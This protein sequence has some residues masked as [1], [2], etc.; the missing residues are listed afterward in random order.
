M[1]RT[2]GRLLSVISV[3]LI[4]TGLTAPVASAHPEGLH[5]LLFTKTAAGAYRHDSIPAGIAMFEQLAADREW[6]LTK[7]E[8]S[9][10]FNDAELATFDVVVM[11]QTSGMVWDTDAQR[12]AVQNY[13][14]GGGGIVAIHNATDMNIEGE[15]PWWDQMLGMSMTQHSSIVPGTAKVAD[16]KH[17]SGQALP[18]RWDR[19]EEWYNFDHSGR[20]DVHVLVTADETTYD[21]GPAKMGHDHPIS[22]CRNIEG[23]RLWATGMGH[24]A[25]TYSEPLFAEHVAGGVESSGGKVT[26]DCGP[27]VWNS[28]EKVALDDATVGPG[29]LDVAK[30]GRVFYAEYGGKVKIFKPDTSQIVTGATLDVYTGG[31]DGLTG[32]ALD[33][34]FATNKWIYL[35]YSPS[36]GGEDIA[37]VSRFTVNGD[38]LDP[39]SEKVIMKVPSSRQAPEPGHTGGYITFGPNGDLHIG[40]GDDIEPFRSDGYAPIDERPGHADNDV[41]GTSANTNDLRGKILRIHPEAD[42]TYTIPSGNMFA[43]GTAKTKPEI[44]AMGFRNPFRFTVAPDGKIYMADYAADASE[45]DPARGPAATTEWNII[46]SPGFY[47]WPYCVGDNIPYVDYDFGTGQSGAKFDCDKPVNTSPN[48]TGLTELPAARKAD[49]WYGGGANGNKFPEMGQG[50][51]APAAFPLYQYDPDNPSKTKFPAYFDNTPFFGE[52]SRNKLFEFRLGEDEKLLKIN[53]FLSNMDFRSPMDMKFGPDGAMYLLEWGTGFG[54]DNPDSGLYRIDYMSGDRSPVAKAAVDKDSGATPLAVKFSSAGS[55]DPENS[56]VTYNWEFGDGGTSTEANPAH[57]FTAKGEF[58]VKL[59]VTDSGGKTGVTNLKVIAGNTRPTV[60][61]SVPEGGMF[62]WGDSVPYTVN[63]VDPED[64][65]VDCTKVSTLPALGHDTHP[66]EGQPIPGCSGV[67]KPESDASH[68]GLNTVFVATSSYT[69]KGATGVPSLEGK[70]RVLMQPKHKQAEFYTG[71]SGVGVV[72]Q[73][74]AESGA[75]IGHIGDNDWA[76]FKSYNFAGIEKVSIRLSSPNGGGSVELRAGSPTGA[77]IATVPVQSTGDWD[78]YVSMPPVN[79]TDPGGTTELFMVFKSPSPS[80]YDIDSMTFI[81]PG[82]TDVSKQIVGI[83]GKC[84]DVKDGTKVQMWTCDEGA[85]QAWTQSGQTLRAVGKCMDVSGVFSTVQLRT[86]N[87]TPA[88]N[89]SVEPDGTIRNGGKCLDVPL[90]WPANGIRL[91][92]FWCHGGRNQKWTLS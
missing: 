14:H 29:A 5:V 91:V 51:E 66:H 15:F 46:S 13:L 43:P 42:G 45:D 7:S 90:A 39:A 48:N 80:L 50:G 28:F 6:E 63:V 53:G 60:K 89:W 41:Q 37:R 85:G 54:R 58:N 9:A 11:L 21:A 81:G 92:T 77:L 87:G 67:L 3:L 22:W 8:D 33:P 40:T 26:A 25:S 35:M 27:T 88:Q 59:T 55:G 86:C 69:D 78:N 34:G 12:T 74:G 16:H 4:V 49:V 1:R 61:L 56:P 82:I 20:G 70:H 64:G 72:S 23:G 84:V 2:L 57:T 65:A 18:D 31:E 68:A 19:S 62:E 73:E 17:P 32:L 75:R 30:D 36:G 79:V 52:W 38:T 47:G 83:G 76:S 10:D 71:S 44:Y 24:T